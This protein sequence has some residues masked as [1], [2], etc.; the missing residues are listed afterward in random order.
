MIMREAPK[1][2]AWS[3]EER[4]RFNNAVRTLFDD[5]VT[6]LGPD[7]ELMFSQDLM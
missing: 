2:V 5:L 7:F 4:D 1:L 6:E 3:R